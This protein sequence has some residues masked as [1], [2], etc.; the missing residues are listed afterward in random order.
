[1]ASPDSSIIDHPQQQYRGLL[2]VAPI[3]S[4]PPP[5]HHSQPQ[6]PDDDVTVSESSGGGSV[7][8]DNM[9]LPPSPPSATC[10]KLRKT[11][12]V[13]CELCNKDFTDKCYKT[14]HDQRFHSG[15][16]PYRCGL[17]GK[18]FGEHRQLEVHELR[19]NDSNKAFPCTV[20]TKSFNFKNDL[21]RHF[22]SSHS[23]EKPYQCVQCKKKFVRLDHK[24]HHEKTHGGAVDKTKKKRKTLTED[25]VASDIIYGQYRPDEDK[26]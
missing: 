18:R 8:L 1:M 12:R 3:S 16:K 9:S 20:C 24:R 11:T 2:V 22:M 5:S 14:Q 19:H 17:C 7:D 13:S 23:T 21:D 15:E 26:S 10:K 4:T 6:Q 25:M